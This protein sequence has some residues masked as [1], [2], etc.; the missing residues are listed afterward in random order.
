ML[1]TWTI[2]N[3]VIVLIKKE[4]CISEVT[5]STVP[6]KE[7]GGYDIMQVIE[8]HIIYLPFEEPQVCFLGGLV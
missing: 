6:P 7:S 8:N 3:N 1:D 4:A 5:I 2:I